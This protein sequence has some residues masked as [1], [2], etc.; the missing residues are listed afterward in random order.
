MPIARRYRRLV[1]ETTTPHGGAL[2]RQWRQRRRR[3]Q[4]DLALDTGIS[5]RHLS[6]VETG[7][8]RPSRGLLLALAEQ[9]E[10]PLRERNALMLAAG[11]APVYAET[12]LDSA[13]SQQAR[14]AI[15]RLLAGH[16]PYPAVVLDRWGDVVLSNRAVGPLLEGVDPELLAPPVNTY[17]LSLHPKGMISRIRNAEEWTAHLGHRLTRLARLTGDA[18]LAELLDEIRSYPGVAEVLDD[19]HEPTTNELL[20][21]LQL[22][23]P[24]G[25]LRL[26]STVTSFGSAH[27]VTLSELT[28]ESFFPADDATRQRLQDVSTSN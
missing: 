3:S 21:T 7:R 17:R 15:E 27:D 8:S 11:Y 12:D 1:P 16:E 23:H 10:V 25:E 19:Y 6:F 18:R 13:E 9:L 28:V 5:A 20:L 2:L 26:I 24:A 14:E 22:D 4:L